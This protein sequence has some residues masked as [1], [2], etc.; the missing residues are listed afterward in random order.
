MRVYFAPWESGV[1]S[2]MDGHGAREYG[3]LGLTI[4]VYE[5]GDTVPQVAQ[6]LHELLE[7]RTDPAT[8]LIVVRRDA[9]PPLRATMDPAL[10]RDVSPSAMAT[11]GFRFRV[12]GSP[13]NMAANDPRLAQ[14]D[15]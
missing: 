3:T 8:G 13:V 10:L 7:K 9:P 11:L 15:S 12:K 2:W 6:P 4:T 5:P 14:D 1:E